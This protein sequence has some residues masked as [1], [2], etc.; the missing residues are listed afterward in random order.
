ML[1][2][3]PLKEVRAL[4]YEAAL[5]PKPIAFVTVILPQEDRVE[6]LTWGIGIAVANERGYH[7]I[8][9]G[10]AA[11]SSKEAA[12]TSAD[13]ANFWLGLDDEEATRIV[14]STMGG[15]FYHRNPKE[16]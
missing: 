7:P 12:D 10:W 3:I 1:D 2:N 11:F 16:D 13:T 8:P 15:Q 14:I 5:D 4:A 9:V 6:N